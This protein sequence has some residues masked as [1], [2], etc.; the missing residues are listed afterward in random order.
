MVAGCH[1]YQGSDS[2]PICHLVFSAWKSRSGVLGMERA[3]AMVAVLVLDV[4][5]VAVLVTTRKFGANTS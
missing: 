2:A 4:Y 5:G 1:S 3:T